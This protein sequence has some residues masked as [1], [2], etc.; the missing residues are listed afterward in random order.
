METNLI[1]A[2]MTIHLISWNYT[3]C[4][5]RYVR[6]DKL[7]PFYGINLQDEKTAIASCTEFIRADLQ[8]ISSTL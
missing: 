4:H 5:L 3:K 2:E 6:A 7:S 8:M 1:K